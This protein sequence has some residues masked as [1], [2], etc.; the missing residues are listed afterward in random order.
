VAGAGELDRR[1]FL[2]ASAGALAAPVALPATAG[3][4]YAAKTRQPPLGAGGRPTG[5]DALA[6]LAHDLGRGE[7]L[8][9][10]DLAAV[11]QNLKTVVAFARGQGWAVRPALKTFRSPGFIS[12]V[13]RRLP[14]PRGLLFHLGDVDAIMTLAPS[15]TDLMGGYPPTFGEL[16][17][18]LGRRPPKGQRRHTVRVLVDSVPLMEELARLARKTR[19]PLPVDVAIEFDV[20]EGKGGINDAKELGDCL[21]ILRAERSR[22]RLSGVLGYDGHATLEGTKVYR[23]LVAA[24]ATDAY[25]RHLRNL[26]ALGSDLYDPKRLIRNGPGSSN[27]RNWVGGPANEVGCG[28]AFVR[29]GYLDSGFDVDGLAPAI[30]Y[31]GAVRRITSDFPSVPVSQT[32]VPLFGRMEIVVQGIGPAAESVRPGG[33]EEDALSGGGDAWIVRKGAVRLG[34]Q[35]LFRPVQAE[36]ALQKYDELIAIREGRVLRRWKTFTRPGAQR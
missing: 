33:A 28:S 11:D 23:Q 31:S 7:P 29:A 8:C 27:Y 12:Y 20:G 15:G 21:R 10:I 1:R 22:L 2:A 4:S 14:E 34:D 5:L 25:R 16:E 24:Q 35:V 36:V 26:A 13:L 19:R 3:A 17:A 30:T 6:K 9:F 32:T 18:Y